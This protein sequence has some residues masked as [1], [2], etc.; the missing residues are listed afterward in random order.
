MNLAH[1]RDAVLTGS[2]AEIPL[3]IIT[4]RKRINGS[5]N[6]FQEHGSII[7]LKLSVTWHLLKYKL[8][9]KERQLIYLWIPAPGAAFKPLT[10]LRL[11][12]CLEEDSETQSWPRILFL[13]LS[14]SVI[15]ENIIWLPGWCKSLRAKALE[16]ACLDTNPSSVTSKLCDPGWIFQR[17]CAQFCHL[18]NQDDNDGTWFRGLL[19]IK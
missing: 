1:F 3:Y 6:T 14:N 7:I 15:S 11:L 18:Q 4:Y 9:E 13:V 5:L 19:R 10:V 16:T 2:S 17:F 12:S 8:L